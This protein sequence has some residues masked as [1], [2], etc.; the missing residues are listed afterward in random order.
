MI[1]SGKQAWL[2][3][4]I[5]QAGGMPPAFEKS[6]QLQPARQAWPAPQS[7]SL[8]RHSVVTCVAQAGGKGAG[9]VT[10]GLQSLAD[11]AHEVDSLI[12]T[13]W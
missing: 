11:A 2:D 7:T 4:T 3:A 12:F 8:G 10:P 9:Q 1:P 6:K 5:P 13:H